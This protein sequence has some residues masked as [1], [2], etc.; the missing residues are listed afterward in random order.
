MKNKKILYINYSPYEN[1]GKV[2]DFMLEEFR[3]VFL[4]SIGHHNI[5]KKKVV[6]K[7][8]LYRNGKLV[9]E[10]FFF[11]LPIP[12]PLVFILLPARS[13]ASFLSIVWHTHLLQKKYG[14]FDYYFTV[15]GYTAWI[16]LVLRRLGFVDKTIYWVCD[17]YPLNHKD[18][19]IRVMRWLYWQFEK[20]TIHSDRL[21]FH[22]NR[23]VNKWKEQGLSIDAEKM[24]LVPIGTSFERM[25]QKKPSGLSLCFLGVLKQSQGV[26]FIIDAASLIQQ[27]IPRTTI[28]IIGPGP[29]TDY[30]KKRANKKNA[31]VIFHGYVTEQE[32]DAIIRTCHIGLAPYV[33]DPSYVSY[34][35]DPG[36]IKKY[37]SHGMPVIATNI[38]EFTHKLEEYNAGVL[39]KYG[40]KKELV[41][42]IQMIK[43]NYPVYQRNVMKL[44]RQYNYRRIYQKM[45]AV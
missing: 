41:K 10:Q 9:S 44:R 13:I 27:A 30:F 25:S 34:Y 38:H 4:I 33:P 26:G 18:L 7:L 19:V 20:H 6:N 12:S 11:H 2:L 14:T 39:V 16:G 35:G 29:D 43:R 32:L 42:A 28:H 37:V 8:S 5:G 15:N 24:V 21:A 36:K 45:F 40:G 17:Y 31:R 23:L 3:H 1:Q 22:N